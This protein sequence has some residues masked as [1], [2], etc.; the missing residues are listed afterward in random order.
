MN[1]TLK[2]EQRSGLTT[3]LAIGLV[4]LGLFAIHLPEGGSL[5]LVPALVLAYIQRS[6]FQID[7]EIKWI[8]ALFILFVIVF[9][10]VS[11]DTSRSGKGAYDIVRGLLVFIPAV[12]LGNRLAEGSVQPLALMVALLF[13]LSNFAFPVINANGLF[14]SYWDN[15]NNAAVAVTAHL[16]ML[17][18]LFPQSATGARTWHRAVFAIALG[19]LLYLLVLANS[20]GAWLGVATAFSS[21]VLLQ[22]DVTRQ[23]KV[24]LVLAAAVGMAALVAFVDLKGFGYGTVGARMEIWTGLWNLT[25]ADHLWLGYGINYVKDLLTISRLPT[26]TAHNMPLEIFVSTGLVGVA[27]FSLITYRLAVFLLRQRYK[28]GPVFYA[29]VGG[30]V[31]FLVMAQVDLKFASF[32]F[33]AMLSC[34]LGLIYSQRLQPLATGRSP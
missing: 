5:F 24:A 11:T 26:L 23:T 12:W 15:P 29:G 22:P 1:T 8:G 10:L 21:I 33:I 7:H 2:M 3:H 27:A 4:V 13:S 31:A 25:V 20:R 19:S 17:A 18:A 34:F 14:Y 9:S 30:F 16:F 6:R 28:H 32:K